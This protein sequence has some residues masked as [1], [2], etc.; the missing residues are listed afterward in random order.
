MLCLREASREGAGDGSLLPVTL[1]DTRLFLSGLEA[2][3]EERAGYVWYTDSFINTTSGLL[4]GCSAA[5][6]RFAPPPPLHGV[7]RR[8]VCS[9]PCL[10]VCAL[11]GQ[12]ACQA[13]DGLVVRQDGADMLLKQR[14]Q[15]QTHAVDL[16]T[17]YGKKP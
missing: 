3:R 9:V 1:D 10:S 2:G 13:V 8:S 4:P 5:S 12:F 6:G 16:E 11:S 17:T 14:G 15:P 7:P